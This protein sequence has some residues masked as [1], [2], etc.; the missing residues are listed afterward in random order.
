MSG[1]R[2]EEGAAPGPGGSSSRAGR[3]LD[4]HAWPR[5]SRTKCS[6]TANGSGACTA[7]EPPTRRN[8]VRQSA[9]SRTVTA[10]SSMVGPTRSSE[11][12]RIRSGHKLRSAG[13][14]T[15]NTGSAGPIYTLAWERCSAKVYPHA[16]S[17]RRAKRHFDFAAQRSALGRFPSGLWDLLHSRDPSTVLR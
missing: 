5:T 14:C 12:E 16:Q 11:S 6:L 1:T 13:S 15:P 3:A 8:G 2:C 10:G 7:K 9:H 4:F 17:L